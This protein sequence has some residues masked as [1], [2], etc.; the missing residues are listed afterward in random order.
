MAALAL[1][2]SR[3]P[4]AFPVLRDAWLERVHSPVR[5]SILFAIAML[6]RDEAFEWLLSLFDEPSSGP[7][8][9]SAL[10]IHKDD[11][12]LRARVAEKVGSTGDTQLRR[13]FEQ[14]WG[15]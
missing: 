5:R 11:D 4:A 1:G 3:L 12:V 10:A 13:L 6:R 9:I 14:E 15:R 7:V 8:A 2:E